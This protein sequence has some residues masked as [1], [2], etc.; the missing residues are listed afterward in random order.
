M[1]SNKG[2][3]LT[4]LA[5]YITAVLIAVAILSVILSNFKKTVDV[6]NDKMS[7]ISQYNMFE[8]YFL[9]EAKKTDNY[10][11]NIDNSSV[12]FTSGNKYQYKDNKIFLINDSKNK[13]IMLLSNVDKCVFL[14]NDE[15]EKTFI[16]VE[17]TINSKDYK[18]ETALG[19]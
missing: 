16:K 9:K 17:L 10:I 7:D 4:T 18:L 19:N 11:E 5:V 15:K 8:L 2:I 6:A 1:K 14:K 13:K 12:L 3:T